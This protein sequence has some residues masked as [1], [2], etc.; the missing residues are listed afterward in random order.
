VVA[1]NPTDEVVGTDRI[2]GKTVSLVLLDALTGA[3]QVSTEAYSA[4]VVDDAPGDGLLDHAFARDPGQSDPVG[5]SQ[6]TCTNSADTSRP[7]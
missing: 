2:D 3:E 7:A 5:A 6:I 1:W 4:P